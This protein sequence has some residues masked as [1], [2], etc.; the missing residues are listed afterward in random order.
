MTARLT[1][2][3]FILGLVPCAARAQTVDD[4]GTSTLSALLREVRALRQAIERQGTVAGRAQLLI[5]RLALQDQRVARGQAESQRLET[6]ASAAAN[7]R[8]HTQAML[9]EQRTAIDHAKDSD[10][11]AAMQGRVRMLEAQLKQE[12]ANLAT[13]EARRAEASQ[14]LETE[15]ARYEELSA[16]FDQLERDLASPRP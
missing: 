3:L 12:S 4:G 9:A 15:R 11:A 14:A 16:R 1:A 6:D 13:L 5:G 10:E 2:A 8:T 7:G